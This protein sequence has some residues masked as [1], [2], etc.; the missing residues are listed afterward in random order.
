MSNLD[1]QDLIALGIVAVV[2]A[3]ALWR[4]IRLQR[5]RRRNPCAGCETTKVT[6][7]ETAVRFY[8]RAP[9]SPDSNSK[10]S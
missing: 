3:L 1:T 10:Q 5:E 7:I 2:V 9:G 8:R 4:R 6:P